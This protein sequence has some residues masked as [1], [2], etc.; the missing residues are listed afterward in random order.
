MCNDFETNLTHW[1]QAFVLISK[2]QKLFI[3][4]CPKSGTTWL[5]KALNGHPQIIANGEGRF[6]WRLF[7]YLEDA[8]TA[9]REDHAQ[10]H[11]C[12][13]AVPSHDE[14]VLMVRAMTDNIFVRYL[15]AGG[16]PADA[17]RVLADKTPQHILSVEPLRLL[18]PTSQ[19]INIVRDPRDAATSALFHLAKDDRRTKEAFVESFIGD[20]WKI[21]VDAAIK[22][23]QD[24]GP[25][26]F[27][28]VRYE[29]LHRD[30]PS[31]LRKCLTFLG[32]D[33]SGDSIRACSQAGSFELLSGGRKRGEADHNAFFRK[34]IVGDWKNHID[35]EMAERCC[36][37]VTES[38]IRFGYAS[39]VPET[40][41]YVLRAPVSKSTGAT[42]PRAN[43]TP[44]TS[45]GT[46]IETAVSRDIAVPSVDQSIAYAVNEIMNG[47]R[48]S[49]KTANQSQKLKSA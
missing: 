31:V 25:T 21:H 28:N 42:V 19:F 11:G 35:P 9:F 33:S 44:L 22:G 39:P 20:S 29:D 34:G 3:T 37:N 7:G 27:L 38:M 16:K 49:F 12:P 40:T 26:G 36:R 6:A 15:N 45:T 32:V 30:E 10:N 1:T 41:V 47:N 18:Y 4:G 23:E 48:Q 43:S 14:F 46:F 13:L 2:Y 8:M 17:V 5:A 24:L